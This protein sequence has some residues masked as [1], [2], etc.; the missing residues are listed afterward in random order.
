VA[1]E[2]VMRQLAIPPSP[3][4]VG[5][6]RVGELV[7]RLKLNGRIFQRSP[8]VAS[9]NSKLSLSVSAASRRYGHRFSEL[10]W[11]SR[12]STSMHLSNRHERKVPS[13]KRYA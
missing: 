9:S 1:L 12:T 7:G 10:G 5:T 13:W 8:L 4:K 11:A 3:L 6:V 2:R